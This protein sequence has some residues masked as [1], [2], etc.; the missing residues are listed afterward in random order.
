MV[1]CKV[2]LVSIGFFNLNMP[3]ATV[4]IEPRKHLSVSQGAD[5]L[6]HAGYGV[7]VAD[8]DCIEF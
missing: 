3:L 7:H 1:R 2:S 6:I 8:D 5:T 4:D